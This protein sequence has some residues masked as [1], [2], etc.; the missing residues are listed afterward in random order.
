[1]QIVLLNTL[2]NFEVYLEEQF[3]VNVYE[4]ERATCSPHI[5]K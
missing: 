1:M 4:Y 3:A 2:Q 5:I